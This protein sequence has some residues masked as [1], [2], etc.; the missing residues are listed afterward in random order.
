MEWPMKATMAAAKATM[1][2]AQVLTTMGLLK[3]E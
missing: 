3:D 2:S 1:R